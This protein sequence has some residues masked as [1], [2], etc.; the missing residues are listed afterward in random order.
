MHFDQLQLHNTLHHP[1]QTLFLNL[2]RFRQANPSEGR[3][4]PSSGWRKKRGKKRSSSFV[5]R[6]SDLLWVCQTGYGNI[7]DRVTFR[8]QTLT[9]GCFSCR[10]VLYCVNEMGRAGPARWVSYRIPD[11]PRTTRGLQL[12]HPLI[13]AV[14]PTS[15]SYV[16]NRAVLVTGL[17]GKACTG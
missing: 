9:T 17:R 14:H 1:Q 10:W 6:C 2:C 15:A 5:F 13:L 4:N 8:H 12:G 16:R 11:I 3:S 7:C